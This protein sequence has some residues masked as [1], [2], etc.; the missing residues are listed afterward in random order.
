MIGSAEFAGARVLVVDDEA[1]NLRLLETMLAGAGYRQVRAVADPREGVR[2]VGE[3]RPD[4]LLLDLNMPH[5]DGFGVLETTRILRRQADAGDAGEYFPVLMLTADNDPATRLK[6]LRS[7]AKDFVNKPFDPPEVLARVHN[8][9]E[10]RLLHSLLRRTNDELKRAYA[11]SERLLLNILPRPV[12]DELKARGAYAPVRVDDV[13]ILFTDFQGFT[14]AA[15]NMPP[16]RLIE[17]LETAFTRFDDI[18]ERHGLE[19]LKTIGDS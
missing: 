18:A 14:R 9:L 15:E 13:T 8:L 11:E 3:W 19:K 10:V 2:L 16:L 12:A 4:L 1:S 17:F 5:L 6:A 7:G